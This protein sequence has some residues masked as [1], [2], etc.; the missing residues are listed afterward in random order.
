MGKSIHVTK[1]SRG[2]PKTTGSGTQ[3]GMRWQ[4]T[5]LTS[6][7]EWRQKQPEAPSRTDAIRRLVELGLAGSQ[8][9]GK[10]N[11]KAAS[12]ASELAGE[13]IDKLADSSATNDERRSRKQRLLKGP[14]EFRDIR[15]DIAKPKG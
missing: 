4:E 1:K 2:R 3:I 5:V 6:I 7:D 14:G 11:P 13:Q 8:P 10:R 9:I 15:G 12:K